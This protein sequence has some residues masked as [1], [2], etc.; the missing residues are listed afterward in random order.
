MLSSRQTAYLA[1]FMDNSCANT[2]QQRATPT[3]MEISG[4]RLLLNKCP[5]YK[6]KP[7]KT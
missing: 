7:V 1:S 5:V 4:Q 2:N 3:Q 6:S